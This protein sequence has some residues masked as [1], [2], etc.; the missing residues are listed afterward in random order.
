MTDMISEETV[1]G[2]QLVQTKRIDNYIPYVEVAPK[3]V[4]R[5]TGIHLP[6]TSDSL[7]GEVGLVV[8]VNSNYSGELV[9]YPKILKKKMRVLGVERYFVPEHEI[10]CGLELSDDLTIEDVVSEDWKERYSRQTDE[11]KFEDRRKKLSIGV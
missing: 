10:F 7:E 8:S 11:P 5:K 9:L 2:K 6:G 1:S 3:V 4:R